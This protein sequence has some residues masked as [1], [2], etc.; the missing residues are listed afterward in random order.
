MD[1]TYITLN[2]NNRST[3]QLNVWKRNTG[4]PFYPSG[5]YYSIKGALKENI[6]VPRSLARTHKNNVW[7][8]V[9]SV[10][11]AS[12]AEYDLYWEIH[13]YDKDI[14]FHCTKIIVVGND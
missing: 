12:A 9:T 1:K 3:I 2:Q 14:T 5:A 8:T 4:Q 13:R 6:L 7:T 11:T 10:I